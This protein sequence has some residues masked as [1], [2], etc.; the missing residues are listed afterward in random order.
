MTI[1]NFQ[2]IY[3]TA[4]DIGVLDF[5]VQIEIE[6]CHINYQEARYSWYGI[7]I[8]FGRYMGTWK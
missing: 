1:L 3:D 8:V 4:T 5:V 7:E 6:S 2:C